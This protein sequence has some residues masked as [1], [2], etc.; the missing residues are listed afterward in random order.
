MFLVDASCALW[1]PHRTSYLERGFCIEEDR[2][3]WESQR[4]K[5]SRDIEVEMWSSN[6]KVRGFLVEELYIELCIW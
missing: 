1:C 5:F 4:G 6:H 2:G 3:E